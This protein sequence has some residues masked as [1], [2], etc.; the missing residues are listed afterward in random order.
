MKSLLKIIYA[1]GVKRDKLE[2]LALK[3]QNYTY[4]GEYSQYT[5]YFTHMCSRVE[6]ANILKCLPVCGGYN[7]FGSWTFDPL[8]K[9]GPRTFFSVLRHQGRHGRFLVGKDAI[10]HVAATSPVCRRHFL[11]L[12]IQPRT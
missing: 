8:A 9:F 5:S 1:L 12:K 6:G 11:F 10:V 3:K 7:A 4:L 2:N